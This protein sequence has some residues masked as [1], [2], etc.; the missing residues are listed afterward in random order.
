MLAAVIA[1]PAV[2]S[3]RLPS[4]QGCSGLKSAERPSSILFA[5]GDGNFYVSH[6]HWSNWTASSASAIGVGH[7]ND[8][9]PYCAAGHFHAYPDT[10]IRLQ[11]PETCTRGRLLF[12]RVT[13]H[14]LRRKPPG[15]RY[16]RVTLKAP[17]LY[18]SGCP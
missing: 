17:F 8:C 13:Y 15:E 9:T 2:G 5:C 7:Q 4:F 18:H 12:T 16:R 3:G 6:L 1:A 10:S 14:F 11:R